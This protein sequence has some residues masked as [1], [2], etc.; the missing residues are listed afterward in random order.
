MI[1]LYT[2]WGGTDIYTGQVRSA[3]ASLAPG[4]EVVDLL[5]AA[6]NYGVRPSAH[7]LSALSAYIAPGSVC[8]AVV[9][10]GVGSSRDP[11]V[12]LADEKW[13]VGPDNGLLSVV[14]SRASRHE[15]WRITWR[16]GTMSRTFHGRDLFSPIAAWIGKGEIP[17]GLLAETDGLRVQ[18]GARDLNEIIYLDHY[19]NALTGLRSATVSN[20]AR[21]VTETAELSYAQVFAD[22]APGEPFW[23][24]NSIGLVEIAVNSGSAAE[25]LKLRVGDVVSILA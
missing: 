3:I 9:D 24:D 19:G 21:I 6:P 7:L 1:L 22:V 17:Y 14:A 10:P 18:L 23:Y 25:T 11:V 20:D 4:V 2:D 13:Y 12:M 8:L 15:V 5:H 16:P